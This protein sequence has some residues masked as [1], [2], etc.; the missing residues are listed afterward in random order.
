MLF[1]GEEWAASAPFQF[2]TSHPEED[3]GRVTAEGRFL[4]F[5]RMGWDVSTVPDP[6]DPAT[7]E[8]S[9]LDW[10]ELGSGRHA[11]LLDV[12]RRLAALR[13]SLPELTDPVFGHLSAGA[14]ETTGAF[15][16]RRSGVLLAVNFGDAT[17]SVA[18]S[19]ELLFTTPTAASLTAAGLS[20][21]PHAGALVMLD[22]TS[23]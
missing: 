1:M 8:R 19:G 14:D 3:L 11:V 2:F 21:P 20:L 18:A 13:H 10:S 16:L 12:Y 7:F 9:K 6:Q 17:T 15:T 4:E 23:P 22:A 5:E